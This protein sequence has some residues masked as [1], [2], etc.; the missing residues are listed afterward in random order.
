M[1]DAYPYKPC[2]NLFQC[3]GALLTTSPPLCFKIKN[4]YILISNTLN[5]T[6]V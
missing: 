3:F 5:H 2:Y 6:I 4:A 1:P